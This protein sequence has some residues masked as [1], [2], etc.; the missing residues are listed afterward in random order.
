MSASQRILPVV[1]GTKSV[2]KEQTLRWRFGTELTN[3]QL[4][5]RWCADSSWLKVAFQVINFPGG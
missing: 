5:G 1:I 4:V 3:T 2:L